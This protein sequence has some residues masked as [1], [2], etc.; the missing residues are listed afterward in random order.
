[1]W[2]ILYK[3]YN[4]DRGLANNITWLK[5]F[6]CSLAAGTTNLRSK[7]GWPFNFFFFFR[8]Q[9]NMMKNVW[10]TPKMWCFHYKF[11]TLIF[12]YPPLWVSFPLNPAWSNFNVS[13]Q[14]YIAVLTHHFDLFFTTFYN[15]TTFLMSFTGTIKTACKIPWNY[16]WLCNIVE[17]SPHTTCIPT[18]LHTE[19]LQYYST[20]TSL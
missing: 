14:L 10:N 8:K 5:W 18:P 15:T 20:V 4:N 7:G 16:E 3:W 2:Y 13:I 1:M 19:T 17:A 12:L 9:L 11:Q 6:V